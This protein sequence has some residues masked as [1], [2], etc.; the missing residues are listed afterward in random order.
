MTI[1]AMRDRVRLEARTAVDDGYGNTVSGP[2][3]SQFERAA[4]IRPSR[5]G[6]GVLAAR[7]E[8]T[9]PATVRVRY[10]AATM[11][12]QPSWRL[13]DVRS[14]TVYAI[15]TAADMER[16]KKWITMLCVAGETA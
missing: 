7:M 8:G 13:V 2:F 15:K 16:R 9:Q 5:G 14:G 6:E 11:A 12:I 3:A 4:E 10:D 1:G